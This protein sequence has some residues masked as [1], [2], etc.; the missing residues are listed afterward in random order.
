MAMHVSFQSQ[1][2]GGC[3]T[4]QSYKKMYEALN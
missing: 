1:I 3:D 2:F 4:M